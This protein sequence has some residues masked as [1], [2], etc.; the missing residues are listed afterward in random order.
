M[1]MGSPDSVASKASPTQATK[2]KWKRW[3]LAAQQNNTPALVQLAH[4]GGQCMVGAGDR[5]FFAKNIAPSAIAPNIGNGILDWLFQKVI[6]GTPRAMSVEDIHMTVQQ[7]AAAAK[8]CHDSGFSG[9]EIHAAHGFLLTQ[10]LSPKTNLRTDDYGGTPAKRTRI[11]VEII[12]A[13]RAVVPESFCVGIKLNSADVG[14]YESL[15]ESL[16]QIGLIAKAGIDFVEVSGGTMEKMRMFNE[17]EAQ[18]KS[19]RTMHREAFFLEYARAVRYRY[20]EVLLMVTGGFRSRAGM[21]AALDSGACDLIG[22]GRPSAVWPKLAKEVLL[23]KKVKDEDATCDLRA[24]R[25]NW[26]VRNL[27]PR[28]VGVGIDALYYAKQIALV[29]Q[30]KATAPP[31]IGA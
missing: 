23:N 15:E 18:A 30:G 20:P 12:R 31:P 7:F 6:L 29:A 13:I 4:P 14:G 27:T 10:F 25:G 3:A 9:V 11:V 8:T 5:S 2:D 24:V 22:L 26:F 16:E 17:G 28:I 21:Q 1:Y 19:A